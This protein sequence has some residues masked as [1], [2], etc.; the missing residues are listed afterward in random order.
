MH[1]AR[2]SGAIGDALAAGCTTN[3]NSDVRAI[4]TMTREV[5]ADGRNHEQIMAAMCG[6]GCAKP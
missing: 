5:K 6:N 2:N 1:P 4:R 3:S